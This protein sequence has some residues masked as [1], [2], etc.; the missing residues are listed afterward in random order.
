MSKLFIKKL[1][2]GW[3]ASDSIFVCYEPGLY[4]FS[5]SARGQHSSGTALGY[6]SYYSQSFKGCSIKAEIHFLGF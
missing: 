3:S 4:S 6:K 2:Q 1:F 5:F